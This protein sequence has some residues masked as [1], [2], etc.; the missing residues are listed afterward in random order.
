MNFY[1]CENESKRQTGE[2]DLPFGSDM[3]PDT[4]VTHPTTTACKTYHNSAV[5]NPGQV[6]DQ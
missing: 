5:D 4:C 2:Q 6:G 3:L 1:L